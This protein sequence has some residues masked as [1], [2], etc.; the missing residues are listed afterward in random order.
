MTKVIPDYVQQHFDKHPCTVTMPEWH[1]R[2]AIVCKDGTELSVQ[3]SATHYCSPKEHGADRYVLVEMFAFGR[4]FPS[5]GRSIDGV[6]PHTTPDKIN[7]IIHR[8][9]GIQ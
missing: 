9:G 2:P 3:D 5:L 1:V 7:A 4:R 6:Y 8:K